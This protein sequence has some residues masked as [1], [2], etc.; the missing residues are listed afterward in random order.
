VVIAHRRERALGIV[1][2]AVA[3]AGLASLIV[4]WVAGAYVTRI[5][6]QPAAQTITSEVYD[7]FI[8][9]LRDQAIVL[10]I[11]G[12]LI[13]VVAWGLGRRARRRAVR[14]MVG[15]RDRGLPPDSG[16]GA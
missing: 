1:G 7:A 2:A 3:L 14:R 12:A 13:L 11:A 10:M 16:W 9:V 4:L 6:T 5:P 15:P 8:T